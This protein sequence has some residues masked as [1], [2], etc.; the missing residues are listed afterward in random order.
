M[1]TRK[2]QVRK[3]DFSERSLLV[4]KDQKLRLSLSNCMLMVHNFLSLRCFSPAKAAKDKVKELI[5]KIGKMDSAGGIVGNK[6]AVK[7]W[8]EN[9]ENF[10]DVFLL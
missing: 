9:L 1:K 6:Q 5:E 3:L 8:G 2:S 10:Q 4:L 7:S